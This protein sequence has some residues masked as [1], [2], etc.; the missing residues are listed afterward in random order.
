MNATPIA[1]RR[2]GNS[3]G[4]HARARGL[5][6]L[7]AVA[8]L[9]P[10]VGF[11]QQVSD[12]ERKC[13][14]A[15]NG[16]TRKVARAVSKEQRACASAF[17]NGLLGAQTIAQCVAAS[18]TVQKLVTYAILKAD[19]ACSGVPPSFGP[20]SINAHPGA[21]LT[22]AADLRRDLLGLVPELALSTN[23][24]VA[25][26]QAGIFKVIEKCE[27]VRLNQF[28]K[29][30]K[31]GLKRGFVTNVAELQST[32]FGNGATQPDPTGGK[33]VKLC[34]DKGLATIQSKCIDRGV[35]VDQAFPGCGTTTG[36]GLSTCIDGRIRCRVCNL[37]NTVDGL[38]R[39][40][41][42]FDDGND[43]NQ[44][45]PEPTGCGDGVIDGTEACDDGGAVSGDGCSAT[46]QLE[47]GWSCS[48]APTSCLPICGD[49]I[50]RGI[51]AC[52]DGG[53][54]PGDGCSAVCQVESGWACIG[55]PS[56]CTAGC[57][58]GLIRGSEVCDDGDTSSGDGCSAACAPES[59]W[60]CTGEPSNCVTVC[61]D[62]LKRGAETCD[63]GG[64]SSGNGCDATCH[65]EVGWTCSGSPSLCSTICGDGILR[66]S[67]L[68]DDGGTTSGNGC[69]ANCQLEPGWT[70]TGEP[71]SCATI[72][73][74]GLKRG[75]EVCDDGD[76]TSGD[77]C[78]A[79]CELEIGW[80]CAGQPSVCTAICGDGILTAS[81][82]CDDGSLANGDGCNTLCQ[83]E[84]G[85]LCDGEPSECETICG[86]GL[87]RATEECDDGDTTLGDGCGHACTTEP[88]YIC[89][90]Q[91]SVCVPFVVV[92]TAPTHGIFTTASSVTVTGFIT[93][94]TPAL[95]FLTINGTAVPIAANRTFTTT[96]PLDATKIFNPIRATVTDL[97]NGSSAHARGRSCVGRR[98]PTAHS[99]RRASACASPTAVS[100][101]SSRWSRISP[102]AT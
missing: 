25:D 45:C 86:D 4:R 71:S 90:G 87:L 77:G 7:V 97:V 26:C 5:A 84:S 31:E 28:N 98:S 82:A 70:C 92:I 21:V 1:A 64:T 83:V 14:D 20:P 102:A 96:V 46:C 29:C 89:T 35:A 99:H 75:T 16:G 93:Q 12:T 60:L 66:G 42:V 53:L 62:G 49:G 43:A 54:T 30:K 69:N 80:S 18:E 95:A 9:L 32:C 101:R 56:V 8:A 100:T 94:L 78:D 65:I 36:A 68:C 85:W 10:S 38:V 39:D 91:P 76:L 17:S 15:I 33:I 22:A 61:G 37:L 52:D 19:H 47:T 40:C 44:S 27:D 72:C 34:V 81:E 48:G 50:L 88:G 11:A 74:D 2:D 6:L 55:T 24:A 41:D 23:A 59:G 13:I 73:G 58:D 67:E 79:L 63:D 3:G 57:G 51:E